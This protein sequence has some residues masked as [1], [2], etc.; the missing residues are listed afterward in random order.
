MTTL[1]ARY[2][3]KGV[4]W[5][6]INTTRTA[7]PQTNALWAKKHDIG[8]PILDDHEG[9]VGLLYGAKATPDMFI[10]DPTGRLVY[11]G[12]IDDDPRGD[13]DDRVNYVQKALDE[14]LAGKP[15]TT[16]Q[17]KAYGCSV[18]YGS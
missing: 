8:Y 9:K 12:A 2:A 17:T 15:V 14:L 11:E 10:I 13:K 4:V 5:L 3:D 16:T 1:A 18:K 7:T 6:A